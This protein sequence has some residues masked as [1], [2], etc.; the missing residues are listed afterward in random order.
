MAPWPHAPFHLLK[1]RG[2][3]MVTAGTYLK[4]H[5]FR[6]EERLN[7]LHDTLLM[8]CGEFGWKLH[9][10]AVFSNHYHFIAES[11]ADPSSLRSLI[12]KLH[13]STAT[14]LN[15]QDGTPKKKR[16]HQFWDTIITLQASYLARLNYVHQN[17]V[18]HGLV[19]EATA[20]PWCSAEQ[21]EKE[22][23]RSFVQSVYS[24]DFSRLN[25]FDEF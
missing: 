11:S 25:V 18:K 7:H 1:E 19:S 17:P 3:Y 6:T 16:W 9:A 13:Q 12:A 2:V 10:W 20:Y 15:N 8:L 4:E 24:F 23:N 22:A 21:F 5:H 14:E